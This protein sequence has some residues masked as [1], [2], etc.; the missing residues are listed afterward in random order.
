MTRRKRHRAREL[1]DDLLR[2]HRST[3]EHGDLA[4]ELGY[5]DLRRRIALAP[6]DAPLV[7]FAVLHCLLV[8]ARLPLHWLRRRQVSIAEGVQSR[9]PRR[10]ELIP[11]GLPGSR[12][13]RAEPCICRD[14]PDA[15][16]RRHRRECTE[17]DHARK[18]MPEASARWSIAR[19]AA[20]GLCL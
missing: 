1:G 15:G 13:L 4:R 18:T 20:L 11:S 5:S 19:S 3:L 7:L 16:I 14:R 17:P 12:R 8:A 9:L 2:L 6:A 10:T